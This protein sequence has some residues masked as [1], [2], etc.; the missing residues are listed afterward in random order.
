MKKLTVIALS[1]IAAGAAMADG[2]SREQ[3]IAELQQAR[4]QGTL[5]QMHSENPSAFGRAVIGAPSTVSRAE[6]LAQLKQ[7]RD[8][9]ALERYSRESYAPVINTGASSKTRAQVLAELRQARA[10]GELD[11]DSNQGG[12][13]HLASLKGGNKA[14]TQQQELLAGQPASAQ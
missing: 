14:S 7:A 12:Y 11:I 4:A 2:L 9:G 3:V 13:A 10:N 6:V 8:S 1:L 5:E